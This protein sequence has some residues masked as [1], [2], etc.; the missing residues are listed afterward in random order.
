M[1]GA[2]TLDIAREA[3]WTIVI[4]SAPL[5]VVGLVVG[6]AVSLVQALTQ[7]QEQTLVFVPKILAMF[8]TLV[9][10]LPFM[11]DRLHAEMLRISSRI[12]GG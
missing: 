10:T 6:V 1:T 9:L 2:E 7:I 12:V 5:M 4:V 3:V 11:A 8:L